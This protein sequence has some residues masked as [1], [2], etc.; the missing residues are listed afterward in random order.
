VSQNKSSASLST[1]LRQKI[2]RLLGMLGSD[3]IGERDTAARMADALVRRAGATWF[4]VVAL[5]A[6]EVQPQPTGSFDIF[7]AWPSRWRATV[8]LCQQAPQPWLTPFER[9]FVSNVSRYKHKPSSAQLNILATVASTCS[10]GRC[11]ISA[12]EWRLSDALGPEYSA[13]KSPTASLSFYKL[14][15]SRPR[16]FARSMSSPS[17][18]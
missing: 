18:S 3:H 16:S 4:D 17:R 9:Q 13:V 7:E 12:S 1:D 6:P 10:E 11:E 5:P 8:Y 15:Q 14:W 2:A